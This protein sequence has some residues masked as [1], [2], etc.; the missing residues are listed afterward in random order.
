MGYRVA[1]RE[2]A[3]ALEHL[4]GVRDALRNSLGDMPPVWN[5]LAAMRRLDPAQ[6]EAS[7][8]ADRLRE[9]REVVEEFRGEVAWLEGLV[10]EWPADFGLE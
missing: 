1:E 9:I 3:E 6:I 8:L 4:R 5:T 2:A 10:A 7:G